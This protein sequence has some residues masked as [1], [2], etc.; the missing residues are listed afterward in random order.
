MIRF[1]YGWKPDRPDHRDL[2]YKDIIRE[3]PLPELVDLR[4]FCS[5]VEN[6]LTLGSC[7]AQALAGNLEFLDYKNSQQLENM[8]RLFI[9]YN[10]RLIEGTINQDSGASLRDGIKTLAK[11]GCCAEKDWE[12]DIT[13]FTQ[14][15]PILCY[16]RARKHKIEEYRSLLD[17]N[18]LLNCLAE[19]YPFVFGISIYESFE[20]QEVA[21]TGSVPMPA[22]TERNLGGHAI[23]AVG[24][25]LKKQI[26][27]VRNSWGENWGDKGYFTLPFEYVNRLA[28]DFWTIRRTKNE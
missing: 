15:P 3:I 6:Q 16:F 5:P 12:Y 27:I 2:L 8:S 22:Q 17:Q 26:F 14:K 9:Y 28:A 18:E 19:G 7:T 10:E 13:K 4:N 25:D 23:M 11:A 1:K 21:K 20:T 24:Y